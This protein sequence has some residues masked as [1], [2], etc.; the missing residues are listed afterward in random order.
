MHA[1]TLFPS[2]KDEE[3]D[4][5][6]GNLKALETRGVKLTIIGDCGIL[7]ESIDLPSIH[8]DDGI[9]VSGVSAINRYVRG[10]LT[11]HA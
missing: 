5:M 10:Y 11:K 7:E 2:L 8:T 1:I 6:L 9:R 4:A 3:N